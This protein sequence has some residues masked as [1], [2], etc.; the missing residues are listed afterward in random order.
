VLFM[1]LAP[2]DEHT[3]YIISE[4]VDNGTLFGCLHNPK[5]QM[6]WSMRVGIAA[7]IARAMNYLHCCNPPITHRSLNA[8]NVLV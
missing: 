5:V 1:G 6:D 2:K 3:A 8:L 4:H 7:Q